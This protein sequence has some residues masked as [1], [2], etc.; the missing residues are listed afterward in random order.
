MNPQSA[1]HNPQSPFSRRRF[2]QTTSSG[3]G[4]LAFSALNTWAAE[5]AAQGNVSPLAQKAP[6]FAQRSK[7][8]IFLFMPGAPSHVDTFDYKPKLQADSGKES[9]RG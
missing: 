3:F 8:V 2:L 9:G 4:Y 6:H 5:Q 1:F 7:R